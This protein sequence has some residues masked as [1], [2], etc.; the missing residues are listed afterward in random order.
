MS[1]NGIPEVQKNLDATFKR[2]KKTAVSLCYKYATLA[3]QRLLE[4]QGTE[5]LKGKFWINRTSTAIKG[6]IDF[7]EEDEG[8]VYFGLA[9]TV[10]YGKDLELR[11]N[12]EHESLR[13]IL[14]EV[15]PDFMQ[16]IH[17][18]YGKDK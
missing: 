9:H 16:E 13:P 18:L 11:N 14:K 8:S 7:A 6:I 15:L 17:K 5:Q 12:R 1:S 2:R 10:E 3:H 4:Q